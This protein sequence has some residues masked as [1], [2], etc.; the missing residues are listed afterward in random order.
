MKE[1][2]E[3][4]I[5][6]YCPQNL[7]TLDVKRKAYPIYFCPFCSGLNVKNI[8]KENKPKGGYPA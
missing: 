8:V 5:I 2:D 4:R 3:N 7:T 6:D 1:L